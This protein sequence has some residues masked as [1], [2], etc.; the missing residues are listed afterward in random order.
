MRSAF[1]TSKAC[2]RR[3]IHILE[4]TMNKKYHSNAI[5]H[6]PEELCEIKAPVT[7]KRDT[8]KA[9]TRNATKNPSEEQKKLL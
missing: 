9:A 1:L 6:N 8:K 7:N 4:L 2:F 5:A 3:E